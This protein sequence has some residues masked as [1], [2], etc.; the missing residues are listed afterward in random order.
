MKILFICK[1]RLSSYGQ[2]YGLLNSAQFV[3]NILNQHEIEAKVVSVT[4]NNDIDRE[5]TEYQPTHA[6]IEAFWVVPEK[7]DTLCSFHPNVQWIIRAHS[8]IPFLSNEGIAFNWIQGYIEKSWRYDNF[9]LSFN[10]EQTVGEI[11]ATLGYCALYTPNIY[12]PLSDEDDHVSCRR[13]G[14]ILLDVG[15]FGAVRPMKNHLM[16]A[17]AS[18]MYGNLV[19]K[20]IRFHVNST[21][22]EQRGENVMK[23]LRKLFKNQ[24]HELVEH[25]WLS[26][27]KFIELVKT[28][29]I[30]LQVSFSETFNIIA[31]DFVAQG[32]P[33]VGSKEIKW[34]WWLYKAK[35]NSAVSIINK[36]DLALTLAPLKV[37]NINKIKLNRHNHYAFHQWLHILQED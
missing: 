28:M 23:N 14:K 2:S 17:V 6:I 12:Y 20:K 16:Q 24:F 30:G 31:A 34:L 4:D 19:G 25:D 29:D 18:I 13:R 3:A 27:D 26:H 37:H 33:L 22:I 1:Q 35:P 9:E 7:F 10:D 11:A 21:R 15:C 5:V 36:I 8:R 32:I